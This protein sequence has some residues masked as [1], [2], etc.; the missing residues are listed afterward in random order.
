MKI[1]RVLLGK[2]IANDSQSIVEANFRIEPV[3]ASC[4]VIHLVV[5]HALAMA[6]GYNMGNGGGEQGELS[7][8]GEKA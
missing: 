4:P 2:V 3:A 7:S 8:A 6:V 1:L 5:D